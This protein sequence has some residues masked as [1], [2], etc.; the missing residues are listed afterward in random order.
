MSRRIIL[1]IKLA[2]V[3]FAV[4]EPAFAKESVDGANNGDGFISRT[5]TNA[6][7]TRDFWAERWVDFAE[8]VDYYFSSEHAPPDYKNESYLKLQFKQTWEERGDIQ[9]DFRVKAKVDLPNTQRK[10][11][12]FFSSDE[13]SD[14]SLEERVRSNSTGERLRRKDSVSGI[15]ITPDSEWHK[16]QRSARLGVKL[17]VP[18]VT[19]GRYR[20]RRPME[21]WGQ[22][23]P[24]FTQEVWYFS[25]RGWGETSELNV[26]RP[27]GLKL[28][29]RY[30]TILEFE[31]KNDYF[32]NV[33]VLSLNQALS[34]R[35][36]LEYRIGG[37]LSTEFRTQMSAYFV[38]ASYSYNLH[39]DWI[40]IAASPE[41]FFPKDEGWD[42]EASFTIKLDIYFS[43]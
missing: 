4:A 35:S 6:E 28:R 26:Q 8:G 20:L 2:C 34:Q 41:V 11:K 12:L 22:W 13:Y 39:E 19:F 37:I 9:T 16:W 25:D 42:A 5:L 38:G 30:L 3:L 29:L 21:K 24:E 18:L 40:F 17:R 43:N 14:N 36:S 32:E 1:L 10:A 23:S 15:E 27:L 33:H 31:D 7:T